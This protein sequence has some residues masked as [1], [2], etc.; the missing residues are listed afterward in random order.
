MLAPLDLPHGVDEYD[1]A[2]TA[3]KK[4]WAT[5]EPEPDSNDEAEPNVVFKPNAGGFRITL[6]DGTLTRLR[7]RKTD[8]PNMQWMPEIRTANRDIPVDKDEELEAL[9]EKVLA[10]FAKPHTQIVWSSGARLTF[11]GFQAVFDAQCARARDRG[12]VGEAAR[13]GASAW[14]L[15]MLS[16][17]LLVLEIAVGEEVNEVEECHCIRAYDLLCI[18]HA[19]RAE[20]ERHTANS[21]ADNRETLA[22]R[23][24]ASRRHKLI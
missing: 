6:V 5:D 4:A 19:V 15:A 10:H 16:V 13:L 14:H 24:Q 9:A 2:N 3:L 12:A 17:A 23:Q 18:F 8:G 21:S 7:F 20:W 1:T 11:K 22:A